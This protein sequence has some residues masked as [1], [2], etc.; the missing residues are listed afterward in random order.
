MMKKLLPFFFIIL[1]ASC[2]TNETITIDCK[3]EYS[4]RFIGDQIFIKERDNDYTWS[5]NNRM[6]LISKN[7]NQILIGYKKGQFIKIG[8]IFYNRQLFDISILNDRQEYVSELYYS[9][10]ETPNTAKKPE[11]IYNGICEITVQ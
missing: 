9:G 10:I 5:K 1:L 3:S 7:E 8:K 4:F 2:S 6:Y 11:Q